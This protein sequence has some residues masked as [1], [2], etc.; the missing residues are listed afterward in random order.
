MSV[1]ALPHIVVQL[2]GTCLRRLEFVDVD[3]VEPAALRL[4]V[5]DKVAK[6]LH[7]HRLRFTI[8]LIDQL[9]PHR[10]VV[11]DEG[12]R[13]IVE[14]RVHDLVVFLSLSLFCHVCKVL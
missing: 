6:E 2:H 8:R 13:H 10:E 4:Q 5:V 12:H 3:A 9:E 14:L 11:A 7:R 1:D